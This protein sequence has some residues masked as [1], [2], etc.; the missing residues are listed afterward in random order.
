MSFYLLK[1]ND[2][3]HGRSMVLYDVDDVIKLDS[4]WAPLFSEERMLI[5][6][7]YRV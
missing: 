1:Y 3:L 6:P 2:S 5:S 4:F 7:L